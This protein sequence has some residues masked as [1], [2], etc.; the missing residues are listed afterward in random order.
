MTS[1]PSSPAGHL[2]IIGGAEDRTRG[3]SILQR[4]V[5]LAGRGKVLVITA[6]STEPEEMWKTY[7]AAFG[8]LGVQDCEHV[9]ILTREDADQAALAAKVE[10]AGGVFMTGGDQKRLLALLGGTELCKTMRNA[11]AEQG[12]CVGGTSAGASALSEHMLSRSAADVHPEREAAC[13]GVGLGFV[14]DA[15]IDQHFSERQRLGRLL[16]AV[17]HNPKLVGVGIDE[18]TALVVHGGRGLE[19][20]GDGAVTLMDGRDMGFDFLER[21]DGSALQLADVRV[22]LLP[23]SARHF[24]DDQ[25]ASQ[26]VSPR[27]RDLVSGLCKV[28]TL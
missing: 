7:R 8:E 5:D 3:K 28:Q 2:V 19:V 20:V 25:A 16:A 22:H 13:L 15:V 9:K 24:P 1:S 17:A 14:A 6:A 26:N 10:A 27:I 23:A 11:Y 21:E 12:L 18:N 4:F